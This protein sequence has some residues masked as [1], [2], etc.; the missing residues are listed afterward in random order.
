MNGG[1]EARRHG[2]QG[3]TRTDAP[4]CA[5]ALARKAPPAFARLSRRLVPALAAACAVALGACSHAMPRD[6]ADMGTATQTEDPWRVRGSVQ[7]GPLLG[8]PAGPYGA[9]P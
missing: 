4:P 6:P 2:L 9:R 7:A 3:R 8:T 5:T 1:T